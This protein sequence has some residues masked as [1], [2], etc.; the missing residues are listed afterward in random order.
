MV[1][2]AIQKRQSALYFTVTAA[3]YCSRRDAEGCDERGRL[4][5]RGRRAHYDDVVPDLAATGVVQHTMAHD[6]VAVFIDLLTERRRPVV[7][8]CAEADPTNGPWQLLAG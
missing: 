4:L 1:R 6:G 2:A 7:G 8:V 3:T 5:H